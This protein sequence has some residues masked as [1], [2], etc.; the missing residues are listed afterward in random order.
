M[1]SIII[2]IRY[3]L[4]KLC[5]HTAI[6]LTIGNELYELETDTIYPNFPTLFS[7][8]NLDDMMTEIGATTS[9]EEILTACNRCSVR[10]KKRREH[11][12]KMFTLDKGK[13]I[14][15]DLTKSVD[16]KKEAVEGFIHK[17]RH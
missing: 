14:L 11:E 10:E 13:E 5:F 2:P 4:Y 12:K 8:K 3:K 7:K 15:A 1:E 6:A 16:K 9:C 17:L